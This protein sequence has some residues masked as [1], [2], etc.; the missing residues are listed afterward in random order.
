MSELSKQVADL[1]EDAFKN[2]E[3]ATTEHQLAHPTLSWSLKER[4]RL[5]I[6]AAQAAATLALA[7]EVRAVGLL[8]VASQHSAAAPSPDVAREAFTAAAIHLGL[9]EVEPD[10]S[11]ADALRDAALY[12]D[13]GDPADKDVEL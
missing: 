12:P 7:T 1:T 8:L 9:V 13:G 6:G 11:S 10:T 5:Q 4:A 3:R 2:L